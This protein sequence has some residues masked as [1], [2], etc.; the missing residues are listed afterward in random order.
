M[1]GICSLYIYV[2]GLQMFHSRYP[3]QGR[4]SLPVPKNDIG[5][6]ITLQGLGLLPAGR[7]YYAASVGCLL[8][9]LSC[10]L[11]ENVRVGRAGL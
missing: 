7:R 5:Q 11:L 6:D 8:Y 4:I 2:T 9:R 3:V 1:K 10:Y